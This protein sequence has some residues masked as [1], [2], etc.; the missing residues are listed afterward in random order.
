MSHEDQ[1]Y[2]DSNADD[3]RAPDNDGDGHVAILKLFTYP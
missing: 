1:S 2:D 3:G